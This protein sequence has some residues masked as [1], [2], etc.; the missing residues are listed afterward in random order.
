MTDETVTKIRTDFIL[1][2]KY[3]LACNIAYLDFSKK[4]KLYP[5]NTSPSA[6]YLAKIENYDV[7]IAH[8]DNKYIVVFTPKPFQGGVLKGGGAQYLV[9]EN[10]FKIV[11][12]IYFK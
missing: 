8:D 2:G 7:S 12:K 5:V 10:D 3:F 11:S 1:P 4:L 6:A 9:D